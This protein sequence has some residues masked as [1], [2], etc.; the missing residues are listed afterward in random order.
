MF[1]NCG[2]TPCD[3]GNGITYED[4]S[5]G[6]AT[7]VFDVTRGAS[8][9]SSHSSTTQRGTVRLEMKFAKAVDKAVVVIVL[10]EFEETI[11][12]DGNRNVSV[13]RAQVR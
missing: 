5:K 6:Y 1:S 4:F 12:I 8:A 9:F 2:M 3:H 13:M 7:W 10:R 11:E